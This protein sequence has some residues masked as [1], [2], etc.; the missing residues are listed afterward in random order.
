MIMGNE[1]AETIAGRLES[2]KRERY[3]TLAL[4]AALFAFNQLDRGIVAILLESI[5]AEM[6]LSDTVLGL[7]TGLGFSLIYA[8]C[9]LPAGRI[10]DR[11]NRIKLISFGAI[12]YSLAS[13]AMGFAQ[14]VIQLVLARSAVAV[15]ESTGSGASS[16]VLSDL[17]P[18]AQRVRVYSIWSAGS[19]LGLFA[20]LAFG[21]WLNAHYGWRVA[22]WATALPGLMVALLTLL[23]VRDPRRGASENRVV[24]ETPPPLSATIA[25]LFGTKTYSILFIALCLAGVSNFSFQ[26]WI[27]SLLERVHHLGKADVGFYSGFF[28]GLMGLCGILAGGFVAEWLARGEVR[29]LALL[30]IFTTLGTAATLMAFL[31]SERASVG[32]VFLSIGSFLLP[33]YQGASLTMLHAVVNPRMRSFATTLAFAGVSLAGLGSGPLLVGAISDWLHPAMGEQS[34]RYAL[35]VPALL[36]IVIALVY[37]LASRT[38]AQDSRNPD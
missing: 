15:G 3:W 10:G 17:F 1:V 32:L 2:T 22:L 20:G 25:T 33:A 18:P 13:A 24:A 37:W 4:L 30:P 28:K 9:S 38:I 21:G 36:P 35:M 12:F 29:R 23:T 6:Q 11:Y 7:M 8:L 27:P 14:N 34:L 16:S 31:L 5:R 19:Y 26:I